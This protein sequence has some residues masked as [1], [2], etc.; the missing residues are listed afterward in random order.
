MKSIIRRNYS[1][2]GKL[3][4]AER[5]AWQGMKAARSKSWCEYLAK[6]KIIRKKLNREIAKARERYQRVN[7]PLREKH[8]ETVNALIAKYESEVTRLNKLI[9]P[10]PPPRS[11]HEIELETIMKRKEFMKQRQAKKHS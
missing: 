5:E 11:R 6:V 8:R 2:T 1:F 10:G 3:A 7:E 4:H 9:L